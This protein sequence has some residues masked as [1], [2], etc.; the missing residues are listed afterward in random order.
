[1][2]TQL[3]SRE[4]SGGVKTMHYAN[5]ELAVVFSGKS[6]LQNLD[7]LTEMASI[8]A[9][10]NI[11][12][13]EETSRDIMTKAMRVSRLTGGRELTPDLIEMIVEDPKKAREIPSEILFRKENSQPGE[14][15]GTSV[16]RNF[17][18]QTEAAGEVPTFYHILRAFDTRFR[19]KHRGRFAVELALMV[20]DQAR[21]YLHRSSNPIALYTNTKSDA[22]VQ[23]GRHPID[24]PY[25]ED[26]VAYEVAKE[27]VKIVSGEQAVLDPTGIVRGAYPE[28]NNSY[29]PDPRYPSTYS[30]YQRMTNPVTKGGWGMNLDTGDA[31]VAYY[32]VK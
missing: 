32:K 21:V 3:E 31:V 9:H 19:G 30:F 16:Q 20:H 28:P 24:T 12:W 25:S 18:I 2:V 26:P 13:G 11:G 15:I 10:V 17:F 6:F 27:V 22:L 4:N 8:F 14:Y 7:Y 23:S 5:G 1:M 29:V